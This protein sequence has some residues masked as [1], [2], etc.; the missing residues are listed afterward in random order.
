MLSQLKNLLQAV[1]LWLLMLIN[2][3][4]LPADLFPPDL[5]PDPSEFDWS[6]LLSQSWNNPWQISMPSSLE[7]YDLAAGQAR[8]ARTA[9]PQ[10]QPDGLGALVDDASLLPMAAPPGLTSAAYALDA[11]GLVGP[12]A[13]SERI[14]N[15]SGA[16]RQSLAANTMIWRNS[17][18]RRASTYSP[19][20][21]VA[22]APVSDRSALGLIALG[23]VGLAVAGYVVVRRGRAR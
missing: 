4:Q 9:R 19:P 15:P 2:G 23:A 21:Q 8:V 13:D 20:A 3:G 7:D 11:A 10:L 16:P 5:F 1:L 18:T 14:V 12:A 22:P 6:S 17:G